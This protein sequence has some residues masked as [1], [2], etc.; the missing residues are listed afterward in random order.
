M[1]GYVNKWKTK[2]N[3]ALP[4][5][6]LVDGFGNQQNIQL[7]WK[8]GEC[9]VPCEIT[10]DR[11]RASDAKGFIVHAGDSHMTPPTESVPWI[12]FA[13]E[14]PVYAPVLTDA[15]SMSKFGLLTSYRL[16]SDFPK[17]VYSM[18]ILTSPLPVKEKDGLIMAVTSNCE[19]VRTEY[20]RQLMKFV[21]VDSYGACL[22]NKNDLV[23]RYRSANG[24]DFKQLKTELAKRY[25]FTLVFFNQD[26]DYFVDDRLSHA[27]DAG[28]V[29][30][31]M[32]TDKQIFGNPS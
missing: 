21:Q 28:S 19:P 13:H 18:P 9:P 32:G 12:L 10:S 26:C 17:P 4:Y 20:M 8:N 6:F 1:K 30:V 14:N 24:K 27:L 22:K 15:M 25:K 16:D 3:R 5:Y 7:T 2:T 29:P 23:A 31:V 11:S